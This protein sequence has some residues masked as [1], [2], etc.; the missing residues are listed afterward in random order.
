MAE[1]NACKTVA[2]PS[3]KNRTEVCA[4]IS[5]HIRHGIS[6]VKFL[7][8]HTLHTNLDG[9]VVADDELMRMIM[10]ITDCNITIYSKLLD[11]TLNM[12][13]KE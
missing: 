11:M 9:V 6:L 13:Q 1:K 5:E 8:Q 10:E 7:H 3:A 4:K 12:Q 2:T